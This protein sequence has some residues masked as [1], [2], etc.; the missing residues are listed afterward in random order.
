MK[1]RLGFF[2]L[3]T[4]VLAITL[5]FAASPASAALRV[6][7]MPSG[8]I[9]KVNTWDSGPYTWP[10]NALE[11]WGNVEYDGSQPLTYTWNFGAGEGSASGNV[12]SRTNIAATHTY[13]GVNSYIATLTVTDGTQT[14]SDTIYIDVI[15]KSLPV[16]TNLAVQRGLKYLY[17]S[18]Q[19]WGINGCNTY[20]WNGDSFSGSTGL[21]VLAFE[22]HGH[23]EMNDPNN[24]IYAETVKKGLQAIFAM[25]RTQSAGKIVNVDSDLNGNGLKVYDGYTATM[26]QQGILSMAIANSATP[27]SVATC[28]YNTTITGKTYRTLL[29]DM[30]DYT[31]FA[32]E[33]RTNWGG[34]GGWRY[35]A[36]SGSSDNSVSQWPAL[37]LAAAAAS[38]FNITDTNPLYAIT[39]PAWVRV[40]MK[41]WLANSQNGNG[42]FG[43]SNR[44]EWLNIAKTGSGISATSF[45]GGGGDLTRAINYIGTNWNATSYD[46]GNKGDHYAMYAV[47]KGLQ[48][49]GISTVGGH[50]WQ[51]EYNQWYVSNK[52]NNGTNGYSWPGSVRISAG[53]SATAF[54]LLVMAPGLVELPPVAN[55][56]I[57]QE[58]KPGVNVSFNG[59][60]SKHSDPARSIVN[61]EWD[62]D[63]DGISFTVDAT[64]ALATKTGGY[65]LPNGVSTKVFTVALRVYDDSTPTPRTGIDTAL[66]TVTNGNVA[67]V[68][69]PGGPYFGAVG[70]NITLDGSKSTD[71]NACPVD[72]SNPSCLADSI[73]KYQ[74]DLNG[75]GIY[76]VADGEP[77]GVSPTVS[78]G[79]FIGTKTIG[80][81]VTDSF[82]RS[83]A[84]STQATTVAVSDLSPISYVNTIKNY[85]RLTRK[86]TIGWKVNI[87]NK[88]TGAASNVK[89]S[90]TNIPAG[91]TVLDGGVAWSE[92][93]DPGETQLSDDEFRYV[94]L[95]DIDLTKIAWDIEFT[96]GLGA[97]HVIR[98]VPQNWE[99]FQKLDTQIKNNLSRLSGNPC[100]YLYDNN[101]IMSTISTSWMKLTAP[102]IGNDIGRYNEFYWAAYDYNGVAKSAFLKAK[103]FLGVLDTASAQTYVNQGLLYDKLSSNSCSGSVELYQG[104]VDS[105]AILAK[106]IYEGSKASLKYG[107]G[108]VL[109]PWASK[110]VDGAFFVTDYAINA[111]EFGLDEANKELLGELVLMVLFDYMQQPSLNN[112]TLSDALTKQ[113]TQAIGNSKLYSI[114]DSTIRSAE[115]KSKLMSYVAN[116]TAWGINNLT[117]EAVSRLVDNLIAS[118]TALLAR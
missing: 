24:D 72:Q 79:S 97:R 69:N 18:R 73:T 10:G 12:G 55:A 88:G 60:A 94:T 23:R 51:Q 53:Q 91:I 17:M 83:A 37:G 99:T 41:T 70:Q 20:Y 77:E 114:L 59:T 116:S 109:G 95:A 118:E 57:D 113:T 46:Y 3:A 8:V 50:D 98:S 30:V 102:L 39:Y 66:I 64:G 106:G 93:V 6:N 117:Q 87:N 54:A 36:N 33:E 47:K 19:G 4:V 15:P 40:N 107:S 27:D 14:D 1:K 115:F 28:G 7:V 104:H 2:L 61:Y 63:Y 100:V 21:A 29:E 25:L 16:E 80:L 45:A 89:A 78:F 9:T 31:A 49:A 38:P 65:A 56:G 112:Q 26:Y 32:Q 86:W 75:N 52:V 85:N 74:W 67:P 82:G 62:L 76:G 92:I 110:A 71:A 101:T 44:N 11:L 35:S 58:V 43:Y 42:G 68:A 22:D 13:A 96:D 103:E 81:K 5:A 84:Q 34:Q 108:M 105:A 90:I 48:Y 111:S